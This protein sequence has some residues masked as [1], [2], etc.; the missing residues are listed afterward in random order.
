[1]EQLFFNNENLG[2]IIKI[3]GIPEGFDNDVVEKLNI[4]LSEFTKKICSDAMNLAK[5]N[6]R[7][8][9]MSEDLD[10]ALAL[11]NLQ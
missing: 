4:V 10:M 9:I 6:G 8:N 3:S 7:E 11:N 1:M 5:E 2:D